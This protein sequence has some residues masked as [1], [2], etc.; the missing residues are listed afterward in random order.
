MPKEGRKSKK[1]AREFSQELLNTGIRS[2]SY[3]KRWRMR[4]MVLFRTIMSLGLLILSE[5]PVM[6]PLTLKGHTPN[7]VNA[8]RPR[9]KTPH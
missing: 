2:T 8:N 1:K 3:E 5:K 7:S 4:W 9:T 6:I